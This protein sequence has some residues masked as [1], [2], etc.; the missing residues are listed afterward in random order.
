M[1]FCLVIWFFRCSYLSLARIVN[2]AIILASLITN[3][4]LYP[5]HITGNL[6]HKDVG[7]R[8]FDL[9]I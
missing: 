4:R 7:N 5:S 9:R 1:I 2:G 6:R 3:N 8:E